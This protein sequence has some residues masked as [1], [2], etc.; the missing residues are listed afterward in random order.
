MDCPSLIYP[1]VFVLFCFCFNWPPKNCSS[2]RRFIILPSPAQQTWTAWKDFRTGGFIRLQVD[3]AVDLW[4]LFDVTAVSQISP[5]R[6]TNRTQLTPEQARCLSPN[7]VGWVI[8]YHG[9]PFSPIKDIW[10][11]KI[12]IINLKHIT[13]CCL[14]FQWKKQSL[15]PLLGLSSSSILTFR[16]HSYSRSN[17]CLHVHVAF[18]LYISLC[19]NKTHSYIGLG[20]ILMTSSQPITSSMNLFPNKVT[21]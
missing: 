2:T 19:P 1:M 16:F 13:E 12:F 14:D 15:A 18:S 21:F 10:S 20:P 6:Y 5:A 4:L 8:E 9:L 17:S 7:I 3:I 11:C